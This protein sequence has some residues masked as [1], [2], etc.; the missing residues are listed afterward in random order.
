MDSYKLSRDDY[1]DNGVNL[2]NDF[3]DSDDSILECLIKSLFNVKEG[4]INYHK[5]ENGKLYPQTERVFAYEFYRQWATNVNSQYGVDYIVN[6]EPEKNRVSTCRKLRHL[7]PDL[8]MHHSQGDVT[9]QGIVCEIKRK[10]GLSNLNFRNDIEK[11][12][13]FIDKRKCKYTFQFGVFILVGSNMGE[14]IKAISETDKG[15]LKFNEN[16]DLSPKIICITYDGQNM[17]AI[18]L[19]KLINL[20]PQERKMEIN[21]YK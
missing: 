18:Q 7:Y 3:N 2:P 5:E 8:V 20:L 16:N 10:E 14:I 15:V 13:Y 17:E 1:R 9:K 6:G 4:Y 11:L 21:N 12:S 19:S